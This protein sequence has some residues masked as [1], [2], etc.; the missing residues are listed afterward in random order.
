MNTNTTAPTGVVSSKELGDSLQRFDRLVSGTIGAFPWDDDTERMLEVIQEAGRHGVTLYWLKAVWAAKVDFESVKTT[1]GIADHW[2]R[3]P[4]AA[5]KH[6]GWQEKYRRHGWVY[7]FERDEWYSPN[8]IST[9]T[10]K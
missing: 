8:T 1:E 2:R 3:I 9:N 7:S 4:W 6:R 10:Q 5:P